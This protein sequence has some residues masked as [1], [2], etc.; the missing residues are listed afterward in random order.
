VDPPPG[1]SGMEH[2]NL[3][4]EIG[5]AQGQL[6]LAKKVNV[7]LDAAV[8]PIAP[9][10][11]LIVSG[12]V[13]AWHARITGNAPVFLETLNAPP[14]TAWL[15]ESPMATT[16]QIPTVAATA[17]VTVTAMPMVTR[18]AKEIGNAQHQQIPARK[19]NALLDA[20]VAP[21]A[22]VQLLIVSGM[23]NVLLANK[24]G[25]VT[26]S[27]E[28]LNAP[29][30]TVLPPQTTM[31]TTTTIITT[32]TTTITTTITIMDKLRNALLLQANKEC[33]SL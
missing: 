9:V 22:L 6:I 32:T 31:K 16:T 24:T 13:N 14:L 3:A 26:V 12:M 19:E 10:Q 15:L 29:P 7:L 33:G 28:I 27:L 25:S 4:K 11:P 23:V 1:V 8:A 5:N 18:D 17:T 30:L 20:A 21:I 2:A